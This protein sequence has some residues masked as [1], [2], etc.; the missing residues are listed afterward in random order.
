MTVELVR[1]TRD[2]TGGRTVSVLEGGYNTVTLGDLA[3]AHVAGLV[4][5]AREAET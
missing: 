5:A 1:K 4:D 3:A 2:T